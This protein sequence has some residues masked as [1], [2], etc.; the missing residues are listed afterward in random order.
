VQIEKR[1]FPE[2]DQTELICEVALELLSHSSQLHNP[3]EENENDNHLKIKIGFHSGSIVGGI[4]GI[5]KI[6]FCLFG[7]TVNTASRMSS[8]SLPGRILFS[9]ESYKSLKYSKHFKTEFRDTIQVKV[10]VAV[11][12]FLS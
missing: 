10:V 12:C 1:T 7:D 3:F 8:N 11:F 9:E 4:V 2:Y 6:Q 5:S